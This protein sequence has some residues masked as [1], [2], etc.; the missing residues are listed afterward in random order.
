ML[1]TTT[2][3]LVSALT[4][5]AIAHADF[6]LDGT[7]AP[8]AALLPIA[9]VPNVVVPTKN[10]P[11]SGQALFSSSMRF[12][13]ANGF[14]NQVPLAFAVR[15]IVPHGFAVSYGPDTNADTLV[16]WKGGAPWNRVLLAS[17]RPLGLRLVLT[18][19]DVK[20]RK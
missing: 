11:E 16:S 20:I 1:R 17:V 4:L 14:G 18:M 15:Q 13:I 19:T 7:A 9:S 12:K 2:I 10:Q 5:P 8:P 6:I 3:A